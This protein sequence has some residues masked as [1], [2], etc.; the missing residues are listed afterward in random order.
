MA[1]YLRRLVALTLTLKNFIGKKKA[2]AKKQESSRQRGDDSRE[3]LTGYCVC[4]V[5]DPKFSFSN[6][7]DKL[8]LQ[9]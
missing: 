3:G 5:P 8:C 9:K 6:Q 1:Y 2:L 4:E 7:R